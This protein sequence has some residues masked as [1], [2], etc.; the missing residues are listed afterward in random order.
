MKRTKLICILKI[1]NLEI[2]GKAYTSNK[3]QVRQLAQR[4]E[5]AVSITIKPHL[6]PWNDKALRKTALGNKS[7]AIIT[8][9]VVNFPTGLLKFEQ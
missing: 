3:N 6:F 2:S 7:L 5:K 9:P 8:Q 1:S 4:N